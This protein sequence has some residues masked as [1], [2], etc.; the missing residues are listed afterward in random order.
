MGEALLASLVALAMVGLSPAL[1]Q[2]H[3]SHARPAPPTNLREWADGAQLFQG[4]GVFHRMVATV[5]FV[6]TDSVDRD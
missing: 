2:S 6:C 3:D 5:S 1:A 4:L